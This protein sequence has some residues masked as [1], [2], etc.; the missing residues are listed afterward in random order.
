[1]TTTTTTTSSPRAIAAEATE[2]DDTAAENESCLLDELLA[3]L[4]SPHTSTAMDEI[5]FTSS[6]DIDDMFNRIC[7]T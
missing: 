6:N 4:S 7:T 3:I 5:D 1:M 2:T